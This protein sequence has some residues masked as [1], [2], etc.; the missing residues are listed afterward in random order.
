MDM[1][2]VGNM[3]IKKAIVHILN[4]KER[5]LTLNDFELSIDG[6]TDVL[7]RKHIQNS[8]KDDGTRVAKFENA[9]NLISEYCEKIFQDSSLF[10][11]HSKNIAKYLYDSMTHPSISPANFIVCLY[12]AEGLDY[13][14]LLKLDFNEIF[15]TKIEEVNGKIKINIVANG[16]G[17]PNSKQKLQKCVFVKPY[18][19]NS[20]YDLILLD[21][22]AS[23]KKDELVADFFANNFLHCKL[24]H[25]TTDNTRNFLKF[26]QRFINDS[27]SED[28]DKAESARSI[29]VNTLRTSDTI[30]IATFSDQVFGSNEE[31]KEKFKNF[32]SEKIGDFS[33]EVDPEWVRAK[34]KKKRIR[35]NTGINIDLD[36]ETS[37]NT[38]LFQIIHYENKKEVDILIKNVVYT[39]KIE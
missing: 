20:D 7:L 15:Q 23:K 22:Q 28:L 38:D 9:R 1:R 10:I 19:S 27:F 35:T 36:M 37:G 16:T 11:Q 25:T 3:T 29:L 21:R 17:L 8:L 31:L 14:A 30:N 32:V 24:A 26:T 12:S 4:N 39:E 33:F 5:I 34:L 2:K 6:M 13:I 18:D